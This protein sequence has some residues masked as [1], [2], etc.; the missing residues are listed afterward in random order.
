MVRQHPAADPEATQ[1]DR[2]DTCLSAFPVEVDASFE[3][4][5][6]RT[7]ATSVGNAHAG[8]ANDAAVADGS[9]AP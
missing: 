3:R 4:A 6:A 8:Q 1:A 2:A 7:G 5:P 9:E